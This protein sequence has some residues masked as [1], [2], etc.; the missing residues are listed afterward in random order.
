MYRGQTSY[1]IRS[2]EKIPT[3]IWKDMMTVSGT[4]L[5]TYFATEIAEMSKEGEEY[6]AS[7]HFLHKCM[8]A[9]IQVTETTRDTILT[10]ISYYNPHRILVFRVIIF[11]LKLNV[12]I[13][14]TFCCSEQ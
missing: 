13:V 3:G 4:I 6:T 9:L 7:L 8:V 14:Y 5:L 12:S 10:R 1:D 11:I 2:H